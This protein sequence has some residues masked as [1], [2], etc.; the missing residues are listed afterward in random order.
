LANGAVTGALGFG[1]ITDRFG[2]RFVFNVTLIVYLTGVLLSAFAWDFWSFAF[3]RLIT[4]L[5]IGGEYAAV[6]RGK[7]PKWH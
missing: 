2:R 1:W 7:I 3:F 4:G 5:G 6:S